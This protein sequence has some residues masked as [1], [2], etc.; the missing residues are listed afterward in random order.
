MR[1]VAV[2]KGIIGRDNQHQKKYGSW[3][4]QYCRRA[5]DEAKRSMLS[6]DGAA[7]DSSLSSLSGQGGR[8]A[9]LSLLPDRGSW[10]AAYSLQFCSSSMYA[11]VSLQFCSRSMPS[12]TGSYAGGADVPEMDITRLGYGLRLI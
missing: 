12:C 8:T 9:S 7:S 4:E 5:N 6:T 1:D 11:S 3:W 10:S 2:N